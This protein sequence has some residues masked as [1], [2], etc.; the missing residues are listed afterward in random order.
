MRV[1]LRTAVRVLRLFAVLLFGVL[2][3]TC[4]AILERV[5]RRHLEARRQR[6]TRWFLR[7][8]ANALPFDVEVHGEL[9]TRP[10]LWLSNHVSW[11]DIPLIGGLLPLSFLSKAEVRDWPL[12]GWLAHKAGTLFIRRGSGDGAQLALK[13]RESLL[14]GRPVAIFPEGTTT[15]GTLLRT[16]H[17][18][19]LTGALEAGVDLQ[20]VAIRYLRNGGIDPIA[21][22]I[23]D[24]DLVSHLKRLFASERAT[25]RIDLLPPIASA[26]LERNALAR[27]AQRAV[28]GALF[29]E[30]GE[31]LAEAA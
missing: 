9:P 1:R 20:P 5:A 19:L 10:M 29:G 13:L 27:K 30:V 24:D 14:A 21:P 11:T 28:Q 26:G 17:G 2:L 22:F 25:V 15:D 23:G 16:F 7:A 31:A 12:A 8:L 18:R 4:V 6:M 3:A